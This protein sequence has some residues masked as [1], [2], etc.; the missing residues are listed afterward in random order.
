MSSFFVKRFVLALRPCK[1]HRRILALD[2]FKL[3]PQLAVRA[4]PC[5]RELA[6]FDCFVNGASGLDL[7]MAIAKPALLGQKRDVRECGIDI[8]RN[9]SELAHTGCVH[10]EPPTRQDDELSSRRRVA[11]F[12]AVRFVGL[13][14]IL[15]DQAID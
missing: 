11:T 15:A 5:M 7:V 10:E 9:H 13:E 12:V 3:A 14:D 1:H 6:A 8:A 4:K 2:V